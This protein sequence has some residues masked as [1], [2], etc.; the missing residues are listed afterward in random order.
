MPQSTRRW[1]DE[2]VKS[3]RE[4]EVL[5]F[6]EILS[7]DM[8]KSAVAASGI[9]FKDRIYTPF[10]T[11]CLFLSQVLDPDHSCRAAVARLIV[12]MA[13]NARKPCAANTTSYCDARLRLP[14]EVIACL[15]RQTARETEAGASASWLWKGRNVSM[16]DGSTSSMP[17][18]PRNQKAFP[19]SKSQGVGLGFPLVRY[20]VLIAL[21]TGVVRDLATGPYK[22]KYATGRIPVA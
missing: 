20:V 3:F 14:L 13:M 22:G 6:H 15:V 1:I 8:V 18:T 11:L 9:K 19:Q 10:V 5:P 17:D 12:W 4:S 16:A 21:A 2:K 7:A